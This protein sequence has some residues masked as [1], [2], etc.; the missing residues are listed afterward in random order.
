M[1]LL[2]PLFRHDLV[3]AARRQR[4]ALWRAA[5]GLVLLGAL[6]CFYAA[7][8][9]E[10]F[11][12]FGALFTPPTAGGRGLAV[13]G[14]GFFALV[15][16]IQ[17]VAGALLAP[18]W[19][20]DAVA[21]ER[22]RR[23][24]T[25][26]LVTDL[27][28]REIVLGK[29]AA[30][31]TQVVLFLLTGL[32]VLSL[33]QFFGGVD[34]LLLWSCYGALA[35]TVVSTAALGMACSVT[36]RTPRAA[37]Q[38]IGRLYAAYFILS[39]ALAGL[40]TSWANFPSLSGRA[41]PVTLGDLVEWFGAG[42]P[43]IAL[44][45]A[46]SQAS[47]GRKF[48]DVLAEVLGRYA[49]FHLLLAVGCCVLSVTALRRKA[50]DLDGAPPVKP[51]LE[52]Y[53]PRRPPV[54]NRPVLWRE[55]YAA[56][57]RRPF[58]RLFARLGFLAA[59]APLAWI[60]IMILSTGG[61]AAN[62]VQGVTWFVRLAGTVAI[63]GA[64]LFTLQ[65]AVTS[66]ERERTRRTL[67]DLLVT[68]LTTDELFDQKWWGAVLTLRGMRTVLAVHWLIGLLCGALHVL[69]V[70]LLLVATAVYVAFAAGAGMYCAA[71]FRKASTARAVGGLIVFGTVT[72]PLV[73]GT[74]LISSAS[75]H[76]LERWYL[77]AFGASPPTVLVFGTF[78]TDPSHDIHAV[79]WLGRLAWGGAANLVACALAAV[80]FWWAGRRRL[81]GT[82]RSE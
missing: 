72:V 20:L 7:S 68:D 15:F 36:G 3:R 71:R 23:T 73:V 29:L 14:A 13:L 49:A 57:P 42:N 41:S 35:L 10:S 74:M 27:R 12:S 21:G 79:P 78:G 28:D 50:A 80:W 33:L 60:T 22:E 38:N 40:P 70:L 53:L 5:F 62:V 65:R 77:P 4:L 43:L 55:V 11:D 31:L 47:G 52:R 54:G 75:S 18:Q 61:S 17:Y 67:D 16:G 30:R 44:Y 39:Y 59:F 19:T 1:R 76:R 34:P 58:A 81:P 63:C 48:E 8:F 46:A 64:M 82:V 2:G 37:G 9:P 6:C 26:L 56:A 25:F 24:L 51:R 69:S 66:I 45:R 32:P